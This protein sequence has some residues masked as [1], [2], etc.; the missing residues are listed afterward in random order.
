MNGIPA[1]WNGWLESPRM[2][3]RPDHRRRSLAGLVV[4]LLLLVP[5]AQAIDAI[6]LEVREMT[7]AGIPVTDA[8]L[9]FDLVSDQQ[10]RLRMTAR[11]MTLPA[12]AGKLSDLELQCDRPVISE[13]DF[14]CAAGRLS[15]RGGPTGAIDAQIVAG[16]RSDTGVT[17]FAARGVKIA[18]T[19]AA[20]EARLDASGWQVK[21]ST[22]RAKFSA[23]RKFAAPWFELPADITGD[24]EVQLEGAFADAGKGLVADVS[25]RLATLDLTNEASTVVTDKLAAVARLRAETR[26]DQ[27][28][29]DLRLEGSA[30]QAL[31]GP[32][33]FDFGANPLLLEARGTLGPKEFK[34]ESMHLKQV[35]LLDMHGSG[36]VDLSGKI[37]TLSGD[38]TLDQVE[39]P[40]A[41][42]AYA[43]NF[44]ATSMIGDAKT[45]GSLTGEVSIVDNAVHALHVKPD[46]L[47]FSANQGS[48]HLQGMHGEIFWAPAGA[49]DARISRLAWNSGGAYGLSGGA[50]DLEFVAY[51]ANFALTRPAKLPVFDG[52]LTIDNFAMG[53]LGAD[54]MEVAFK[55]AVQPI[56]MPLLAKAFG[57]PEF[58]GKLAASIPGVRLKDNLL[59][60]DGNVE[61]EVFGGKIT[62]SNIRLQDPLGN[63][64]QF[65]ADVRAR[66]LDLGLVTQTFEVGSITGKLEVDV[67]GLELF[68]WTPQAF[69]ARLATPKGDKSRHRISAK[70]VSSLS[71]V[72][73][74]GG[75]VVQALQSGVLKFFDEYS[76][77]KIGIRCRLIGEV[78]E[79]SGVEPA[80]NG[81]YIVKG[82]GIP[83]IDI[84]GNQGR[85]N[86]N[87]LMS[88][89]ATADFGGT[90]V[91]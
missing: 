16:L 79:M 12:P 41:F 83:R 65:F 1:R 84:V 56:S 7:V 91:N 14:G 18:G 85:V 72:G 64:P 30:G 51:G 89:I 86:W 46:D 57:W 26:G 48:L 9:R 38:F 81:Y 29:L 2:K 42:T 32:V 40:A 39:F 55:G 31:G 4:G 71:N 53:N 24:G 36:R 67:L 60:F 77:D 3:S 10:T 68:D 54:N 62:G 58:A 37:P 49:G 87:Q 17:T 45:R 27:T 61:S 74:G 75:G 59:T 82:A 47:D 63:H 25:A 73:G 90:T 70:A 6:E 76:Y 33:Y 43:A 11:E 34:L 21:G 50:A 19:T 28:L 88:S 23:L 66:D 69:D 20:V 52:A 35:K 80:P 15:A 13:P 8:R 44:L 78:C 22:A 5:A